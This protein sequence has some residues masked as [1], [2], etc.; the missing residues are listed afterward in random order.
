MKYCVQLHVFEYVRAPL[1]R[2]FTPYALLLYL[3]LALCT[4]LAATNTTFQYLGSVHKLLSKASCTLPCLDKQCR[5]VQSP[6][7]E[8]NKDCSK[9]IALFCILRVESCRVRGERTEKRASFVSKLMTAS[10]DAS[11]CT[12]RCS[13]VRIPY[14][15][16]VPDQG[17]APAASR[18]ATMLLRSLFPR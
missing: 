4:L 3:L 14:Y 13:Y 10:F 7:P 5:L 1:S 17:T 12:R 16:P 15:W 8:L 2:L 11:S 9:S 18:I 6:T